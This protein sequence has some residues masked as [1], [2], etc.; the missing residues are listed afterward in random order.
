M[1]GDD[2]ALHEQFEELCAMALLGE[3]SEHDARRLK[4]HLAMCES[5]RACGRDFDEIVHEQMPL[6]GP[7]P[8]ERF[9]GKLRTMVENGAYRRRFM[10]RAEAAGIKLA[11]RA[12][13][14]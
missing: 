7:A 12:S 4:E 10:V 11:P 5:C 1:P 9:S 2:L 13:P 14:R 8:Q 3:I 6:V